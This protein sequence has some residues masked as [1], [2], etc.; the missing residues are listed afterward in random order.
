MKYFKIDSEGGTNHIKEPNSKVLLYTDKQITL[1]NDYN[2]SVKKFNNDF[3]FEVFY[4]ADIIPNGNKIYVVGE[5]FPDSLYTTKTKI[6]CLYQNNRW[7]VIF[8]PTQP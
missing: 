5:P 8:N 7:L 1:T 4:D 3:Y 2:L 6:S